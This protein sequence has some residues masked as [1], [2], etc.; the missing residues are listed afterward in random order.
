LP[1][2]PLRNGSLNQL[3]YSLFLFI[4][5]LAGG[6]LVAWIDAQ[7]DTAAVAAPIKSAAAMGQA[8]IGPLAHI[9]GVSH[10]VLNMTLASLLLGAGRGKPYW[11][12]T[13][14]SLIAID[15]LV[16]NF[17]ARTGILQRA[18]GAHAYGPACYGPAGC[19]EVL[20]AISRAIDARAFNP[21]FPAHFPRF[22]QSAIWAYCAGQGLNVCNGNKID[23][24]RPCENTECRIYSHCDGLALKSV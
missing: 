23:D 7:L 13:G 6:D 17:L 22:V 21:A 9:H 10:K 24:C 14:A 2:L 5:D 16:H 20:R 3:A 12:E 8:L 18:N 11:V 4:R 15:T 19:A 1:A